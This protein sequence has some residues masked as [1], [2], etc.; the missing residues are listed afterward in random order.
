MHSFTSWSLLCLFVVLPLIDANSAALYKARVL[1][2]LDGDSLVIQSR[3]RQVQVRLAGIDAPEYN[4]PY[5]QAARNALSTLVNGHTVRVSPVD[6]DHYGRVVA[7][8]YVGSRDVNLVLVRSG[9]AWVYRAYTQDSALQAAEQGARS[10]RRGLWASGKPV[11]PW[12]WRKQKHG[13][14][15][16]EPV[17]GEPH[18]LIRP[19]AQTTPKCN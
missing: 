1:R 8:I 18:F 6:H 12:I 9:Y 3:D 16:F 10:A 5:G 19:I 7:R 4:Q 2:V 13:S 15:E 17:T 11:P 14:I